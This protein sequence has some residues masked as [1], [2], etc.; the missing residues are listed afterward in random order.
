MPSLLGF[1]ERRVCDRCWLKLDSKQQ[2]L[3][4]RSRG[5]H[6]RRHS[7]SRRT[8]RRFY[9]EVGE[10]VLGGNSLMPIVFKAAEA[11]KADLGF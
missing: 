9:A 6:A 7:H 1:L 2:A 11:A 10:P 3:I 5:A 8:M 4:L